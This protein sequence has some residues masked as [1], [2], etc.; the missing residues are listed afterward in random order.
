MTEA[1][2]KRSRGVRLNCD[3]NSRGLYVCLSYVRSAVPGRISHRDKQD[4]T[5][6]LHVQ[7][8]FAD[9]HTMVP[10]FI[11]I[12]NILTCVA[13]TPQILQLQHIKLQTIGDSERLV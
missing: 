3:S 8:Y 5:S 9:V 6:L 12:E 2:G 13:W 10:S 11:Q 7:S 4:P 1:V